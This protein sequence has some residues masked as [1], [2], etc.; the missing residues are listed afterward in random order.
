VRSISHFCPLE[1]F[2]FSLLL[3]KPFAVP[4]YFG[5]GVSMVLFILLDI[6]FVLFDFLWC[7][8]GFLVATN[9]FVFLLVTDE[10][11]FAVGV[12]GEAKA[13]PA[14]TKLKIKAVKIPNLCFIFFDSYFNL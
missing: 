5:L 7:F 12:W 8:F 14:I 4:H 3:L 2:Y 11:F 6:F 10:L 13:E 9:L 1:N